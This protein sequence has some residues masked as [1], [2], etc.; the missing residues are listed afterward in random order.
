MREVILEPDMLLLLPVKILAIVGWIGL[1]YI[2]RK[3]VGNLAKVKLGQNMLLVTVGENTVPVPLM[4][5][6][7]VRQVQYS[8]AL[9][10]VIS[11][12]LN[13]STPLGN[14]ISFVPD[15]RGSNEFAA[16]CLGREHPMVGEL[17]ERISH[18]QRF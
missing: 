9:G 11:I 4:S 3:A 7:A 1:C 12:D 13:D 10:A 2:L 14:S 8:K 18:V 15:R 5:I 17:Q 16:S 6:K